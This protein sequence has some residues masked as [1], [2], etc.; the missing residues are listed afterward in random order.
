MSALKGS[1]RAGRAV[2]MTK[3]ERDNG[4]VS[5]DVAR[6]CWSG[7][8]G[9]VKGD[10]YR[11]SHRIVP[12]LV[13]LKQACLAKS[14]LSNA[15]AM[16]SQ[17]I[18]DYVPYFC[19]CSTSRAVG[20]VDDLQ[21]IHFRS[22]NFSTVDWASVSLL[23][24]PS[25]FC[26]EMALHVANV[27]VSYIVII[28]MAIEPVTEVWRFNYVCTRQSSTVPDWRVS[29]PHSMIAVFPAISRFAHFHFPG[30]L[31]DIWTRYRSSVECT[32]T[33]RMQFLGLLRLYSRLYLNSVSRIFDKSKICI[34][35]K[36]PHEAAKTV[37]TKP[38]VVP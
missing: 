1:L 4:I 27:V 28:T 11:T 2:Q 18:Q 35:C 14:R 37:K 20:H 32:L 25:L 34:H 29:P 8:A 5:V 36:F 12:G 33:T 7:M 31:D 38:H 3:P 13:R 19:I 22:G 21:S 15:A 16:P 9:R 26:V 6:C 17:Q 24:L 23:S 30:P 10:A